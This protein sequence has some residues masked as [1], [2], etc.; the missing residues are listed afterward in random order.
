MKGSLDT[1]CPMIRVV[2]GSKDA[3]IHAQT[4]ICAAKKGPSVLDPD[5]RAGCLLTDF[6]VQ[7]H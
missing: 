4:Y 7:L 3:V 6:A 5:C 1:V 2:S